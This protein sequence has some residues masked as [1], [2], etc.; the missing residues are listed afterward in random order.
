MKDNDINKAYCKIVALHPSCN[1]VPVNYALNHSVRQV[2]GIYSEEDINRTI[3]TEF[4]P[5]FGDQ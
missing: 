5:I 1:Y 4:E 3:E 2:F